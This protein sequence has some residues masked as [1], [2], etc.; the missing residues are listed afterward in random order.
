MPQAIP[1]LIAAIGQIT[2][3]QVIFAVASF[4]IS[5]AMQNR[6]QKKAEAAQRAAADAQRAAYNA[7]LV[8][9]KTVVRSAIQPRNMIL[10]RDEAAGPLACWFTYGPLRNYHAFA[11][12]LAG[13]ECDEIETVMFNHEPVTLDGSGG[14]IAPAKYTRI[15]TTQHTESFPP[16]VAGTVL[17]LARRPAAISTGVWTTQPQSSNNIA[18]TAPVPYSWDGN[19]SVTVL[20]DSGAQGEFQ[21]SPPGF[22]VDY[23]TVET[24]PLFYIKKYLGAPGQT[25]APELIAAAAAAGVPGSWGSDRKGTS[26]CYITCVVDADFNILG[27]IGIPNLSA[28]TRGA[29]PY[30]VRTGLTQWT[31]NP[32]DLSRWFTVQSGYAPKTLGTEVNEPQLIASANVCDEAVAFSASRLEAR[33]TCNGQLTTAASPMD[34]LNHILDSMDG[35]A[36][37]ISGQWQFFAG[38]YREP[39]LEINED[40]LSSAGISVAPRTPKRDLFNAVTGMYV[41]PVAGYTRTSYTMV[42]SPVYQAED[43]GELLPAEISFELVNDSVRCEMI[44]WQRLTRARQPLTVQLGTTL[45]GYDTAPMQNVTLNIRKLG[46]TNKV[47]TNIRREFDAPNLVHVLQETGPEVWAWDY[48]QAAAAVDLPNTSFPDVATIPLVTGITLYS[49]TDA[50][51]RLADGTIISRGRIR[52][53]QATNTYVLQGGCVEWQH[54]SV[55][56]TSDNWTVLPPAAGGDVEIFTGP[57]ADGDARVVRGRFVTGQG[58]V[59][60]WSV[61]QAFVVVGKTELPPDVATFSVDLDGNATWPDATGVLDLA[62][63]QIRWQPGNNNSWGDATPLHN[64]LLQSSPYPIGV[65]PS[66]VAT[67]MIKF[68]DSSGNES[69]NAAASVINLGDPIVANVVTS[70]DFKAA[71]WPGVYTGASISGGNLAATIDPSPL[72]WDANAN[73]AGWTLDTDPGWSSATYAPVTYTATIFEVDAA[74]TGAQLTLDTSISGTAY[75]IEYRRD[76]DAAGWTS[77]AEP[78]WTDD[79]ALAWVTSTYQPWP[80]AVTAHAGRYE[81][82]VSIQSL[83]VQGV[84]STMTANLDVADQFE[85]V[86]VVSIL[87]GGTNIPTAFTWRAITGVGLTLVGDGGTARNV[88]IEDVSTALIT[89]RDSTNVAVDGTVSATLQGY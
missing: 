65:R 79:A 7:G 5:T 88:R 33:Y 86:G 57:L 10:G 31:Q 50:L 35:D 19:L 44:A 85:N 15:V 48:T 67:F 55:L 20:A 68:V 39:T 66:G 51:L 47:F 52:W 63:A 82:R 29:K 6:A 53:T 58:R 75:L 1:A 69:A 25:A 4:A 54:K 64:G 77:D 80:G 83:D 61:P 34:N 60:Q 76:G 26:V 41:S 9:R 23:H 21:T 46:Y 89:T 14:V 27:Q 32:A 71:G 87:A 12:V 8:D 3:T 24:Q 59:G 38:Y 11:V 18:I 78:G 30:N 16:G 74:D 42:T 13:H 45:K 40:T 70:Y 81:F 36:V 73:T 56:D 28:V 49:G 72:A 62:G 37:W 22:T 17:T 2:V 43:G 84:I